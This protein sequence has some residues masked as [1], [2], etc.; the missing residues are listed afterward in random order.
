MIPDTFTPFKVTTPAK[1]RGWFTCTFW[2][3]NFSS[4]HVLCERVVRWPRVIGSPQMGCCHWE[5]EPG[6]DDE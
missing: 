2:R 5:R 1:A 4:G 6:S 3:G